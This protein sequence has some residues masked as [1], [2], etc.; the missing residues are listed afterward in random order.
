[1]NYGLISRPEYGSRLNSMIKNQQV[2]SPTP[3]FI[4]IG[5]ATNQGLFTPAAPG[6]EGAAQAWKEMADYFG[7]P[8]MSSRMSGGMVQR[9]Q[10]TKVGERGPELM[11]D[12]NGVR[13]VG[14]DG[15]DYIHSKSNGYITPNERLMSLPMRERVGMKSMP[16]RLK[17]T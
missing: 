2:M 4:G 7:V 15:P 12:K 5:D 16:K 17:Y 9:G 11:R 1:M 3:G 8:M 6:T 13:V 10:M 14:K